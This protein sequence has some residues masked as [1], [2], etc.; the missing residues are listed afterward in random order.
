MADMTVVIYCDTADVNSNLVVAFS[1]N[2]F[3]SISKFVKNFQ[4]RTISIYEESLIIN[5]NIYVNIFSL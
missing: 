1:T 4:N 2:L 3:K 5:S